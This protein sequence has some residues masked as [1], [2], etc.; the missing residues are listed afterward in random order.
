MKKLLCVAIVSLLLSACGSGVYQ[1]PKEEYQSKVQVLGVLPLLVDRSTNVNY[2][3]REGLFDLLERSV[4]GRQGSLVAKL[5]EKKGYFDVR[6]LP[7]DSGLIGMSLLGAGRGHNDVGQPTAYAFDTATV[8]EMARRNVVDA[9]LIVVLSADRVTETQR[10]RTKLESLRTPFEDV[11]ATAAVVDRN[12]QVLWQ[13]AGPEAFRLLMLQYPDFDEAYY[14]QT[15]FV[16]VKDISLAGIE[17][18]LA[19][20]ADSQGNVK[21]PKLYEALFNSIVSGISPSLLDSI[22]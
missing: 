15:D 6:S 7:I 22:R 13:M 5:K 21:P 12:G 2:P 14:N 20:E 18:G 16:R 1:I 17:K 8:V 4:A 19:G 9:L 3:Q 11:M 10:S